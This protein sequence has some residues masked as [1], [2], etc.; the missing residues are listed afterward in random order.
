MSAIYDLLD[1]YSEKYA[2]HECET[3]IKCFNQSIT[4]LDVAMEEPSLKKRL[5]GL[6]DAVATS[7][8]WQIVRSLWFLTFI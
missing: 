3:E 1:D 6:R 5:Q 2:T 4:Q 7:K 8:N